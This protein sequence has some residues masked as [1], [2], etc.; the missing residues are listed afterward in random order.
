MICIEPLQFE[1]CATLPHFLPK[2]EELSAH[3]LMWARFAH[4]LKTRVNQTNCLL[5]CTGRLRRPED[6]RLPPEGYEGL[7]TNKNLMA[8]LDDK[9][10]VHESMKE[11]AMRD[12]QCATLSLSETLQILGHLPLRTSIIHALLLGTHSSSPT[13]AHTSRN[14]I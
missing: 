13:S 7:F 10:Y 1:M 2:K 6:I 3:N 8:A 9:E 4:N 14:C 12:F 5:G 11:T